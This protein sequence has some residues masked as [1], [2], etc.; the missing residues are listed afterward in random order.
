[1]QMECSEGQPQRLGRASENDGKSNPAETKAS[2]R[3]EKL[4]DCEHLAF[5]LRRTA[6]CRTTGARA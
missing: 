1:M 6:V 5:I 4:G 3:K 2:A